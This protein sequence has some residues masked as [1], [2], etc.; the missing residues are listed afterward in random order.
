M[1]WNA[2]A[3]TLSQHLAKPLKILK[4][5]SV[6]GGDINQA[7][8]LQT[9]LGDIFVKLNQ[10]HFVPMM[11][12]EARSLEWILQTQTISCPKP[13]AVGELEEYSWLAM[14]Y[15]P[16]TSRG[17]D[18]KKGQALTRLHQHIRQEHAPFGWFEDNFIGKTLQKNAWHSN[19]PSFYGSQRLRPQIELA[20]LHGAPKRWLELGESLIERLPHFFATYEPQA[21]LL[22]GDLWGGNSGFL[23]DGTPIIFDPASYFGD[24]ETDL[25]M[26]ELFGG[27]SQDFYAAYNEILPIHEDYQ[28]R[29][30]LYNLYHL[31]NHFNLFGGGYAHQADNIMHRLIRQVC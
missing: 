3:D 14:E 7:Y 8:R 21:S 10:A 17:S 16:I 27:Y 5:E 22:H 12:A 20:V 25:A 23:T 4:A 30:P 29:K 9:N 13:L 11:Q 31:L 6:A 19:W 1:N 28:L 24:R 26:T 2:F 15:V 18:A